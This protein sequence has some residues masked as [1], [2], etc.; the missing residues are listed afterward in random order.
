[1]KLNR[2]SEQD[3]NRTKNIIKIWQQNRI[4]QENGTEHNKNDRSELN[5]I[6]FDKSEDNKTEFEWNISELQRTKHGIYPN[7][8]LLKHD[9]TE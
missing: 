4:W 8:I 9:R 7:K 1:M 2:I 5:R 3:M 6:E